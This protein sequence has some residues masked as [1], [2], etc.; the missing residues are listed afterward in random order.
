MDGVREMAG[1]GVN[2]DGIICPKLTRARLPGREKNEVLRAMVQL[3][4]E[5]VRG[6][7]ADAV[8]KAI[9]KREELGT[10]ALGRGVAFPH[11]MIEGFDVLVVAVATLA[12]GVDFEAGDGNPVRLVI[13]AVTGPTAP[14]NYLETLGTFAGISRDLRAMTRILSADS[15]EALYSVI[16]SL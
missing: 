4:I 15:S 10:T 2:L 6:L 13:M 14:H 11:A 12:E 9:L 5:H 3:I 16:E 8:L 1:I 7:D